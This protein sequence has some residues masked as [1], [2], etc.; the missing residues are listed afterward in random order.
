MLMQRQRTTSLA[1]HMGDAAW[2]AFIIWGCIALVT[3]TRHYMWP[4]L[5]QIEVNR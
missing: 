2:R 3:V 4:V 1:K 5:Y